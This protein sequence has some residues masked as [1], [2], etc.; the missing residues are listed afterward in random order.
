MLLN[1]K[2]KRRDVLNKQSSR[3][4]V[5]TNC[6]WGNV[7]FSDAD[8]FASILIKPNGELFLEICIHL[9]AKRMVLI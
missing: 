7:S 1:F 6:I 9:N 3:F 5:G 8:F 4:F 2:Q